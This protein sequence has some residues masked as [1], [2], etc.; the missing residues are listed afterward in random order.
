MSLLGGLADDFPEECDRLVSSSQRPAQYHPAGS[1]YEHHNLVIF[2]RMHFM[3]CA[4]RRWLFGFVLASLPESEASAAY[5]PRCLA[6]WS[7]W[8][9]LK[10]AM[11]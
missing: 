9:S 1:H 7:I 10:L 6:A 2:N 4:S 5:R 8:S 11:K 3:T